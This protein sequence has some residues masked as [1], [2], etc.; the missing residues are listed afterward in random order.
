MIEDDMFSIDPLSLSDMN[1]YMK[2]KW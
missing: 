2:A 1:V